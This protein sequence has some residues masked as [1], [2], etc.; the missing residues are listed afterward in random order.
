MTHGIWSV[1]MVCEADFIHLVLMYHM[2]EV[3][4]Y[5]PWDPQASPVTTGLKNLAD[6]I[7]A[8]SSGSNVQ[9]RCCGITCSNI[10]AE[11]PSCIHAPKH[12][13]ISCTFQKPATGVHA[14]LM[15]RLASHHVHR[16]KKPLN[17]WWQRVIPDDRG[18]HTLHPFLVSDEEPSIGLWLIVASSRAEVG[19]PIHLASPGGH[20]RGHYP[21]GHVATV[22][23]SEI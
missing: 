21:W 17:C 12:F 6:S 7:T 20:S 9:G 13:W 14:E 11:L 10:T 8:G 22:N 4:S 15:L 23:G 19:G 16:H 18:R 2:W 5:I 3:N 1:N